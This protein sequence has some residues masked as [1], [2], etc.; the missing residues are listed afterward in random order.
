M[1]RVKKVNNLENY[2]FKT[3]SRDGEYAVLNDG[4][5]D[6]FEMNNIET[7]LDFAQKYF[8]DLTDRCTKWYIYTKNDSIL[9]CQKD[10]LLCKLTEDD[11][12]ML[13]E[14]KL[15]QY[16]TEN[17]RKRNEDI[18]RPYLLEIHSL[19]LVVELANNLRM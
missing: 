13:R 9:A 2:A 8:G 10:L 1:V 3:V 4:F 17:L 7:I 16:I 6:V 18:T 5:A 11:Y 12:R 14:T 15:N 19:A